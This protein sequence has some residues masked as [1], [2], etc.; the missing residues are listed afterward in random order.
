MTTTTTQ[1][2]KH[3]GAEETVFINSKRCVH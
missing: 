3:T 1:D 2:K